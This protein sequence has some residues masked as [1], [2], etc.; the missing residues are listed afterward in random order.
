MDSSPHSPI[1]APFPGVPVLG[2]IPAWKVLL[3]KNVLSSDFE[4]CSCHES[5]WVREMKS[6][7]VA[8]SGN[9][10][11]LRELG[12]PGSNLRQEG[13]RRRQVLIWDADPSS[14]LQWVAWV[15]LLCSWERWFRPLQKKVSWQRI[16]VLEPEVENVVQCFSKFATHENPLG[17]LK[18]VP[19]PCHIPDKWCH[20]LGRE[21]TQPPQVIPLYSQL[22][23]P[24][25]QEVFCKL[26]Y[27]ANPLGMLFK[28]KF[29]CPGL[30]QP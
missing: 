18:E 17:G 21:R 15:T 11:V 20:T 3:K 1:L 16:W 5:E 10:H 6:Q 30:E 19:V 13:K 25:L 2:D 8:F 12:G 9:D 29:W 7:K 23:E 24:G 28:C 14:E 27:L 26:R 22:W 4:W